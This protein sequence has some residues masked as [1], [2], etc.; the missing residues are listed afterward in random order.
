MNTCKQPSLKRSTLSDGALGSHCPTS[1]SVD[2]T[3]SHAK[4]G[5]TITLIDVTSTALCPDSKKIT[6]IRHHWVDRQRWCG[7]AGQLLQTPS[8]SDRG[9]GQWMHRCVLERHSGESLSVFDN[10]VLPQGSFT[11][12]GQ[13]PG[14][15]RTHWHWLMHTISNR[16]LLSPRENYST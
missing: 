3:H 13:G 12:A 11:L 9:N 16:L 1:P 5:G 6:L 14:M 2:F 8:Y 7:T 15:N 4:G 10:D